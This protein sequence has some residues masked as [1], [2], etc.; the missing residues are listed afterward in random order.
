[1]KNARNEN[2]IQYLDLKKLGKTLR[3]KCGSRVLDSF[4]VPTASMPVV[5]RPPHPWWRPRCPHPP[6]ST[7]GLYW[8]MRRH[9]AAGTDP[10]IPRSKPQQQALSSSSRLST[11]S[12]YSFSL[13]STGTHLPLVPSVMPFVLSK[14]SLLITFR[15]RPLLIYTF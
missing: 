10:K 13:I 1:M 6:A 3:L 9:W 14:T 8:S 12:R 7:F 11:A 4:G 15:C 5:A 2:L